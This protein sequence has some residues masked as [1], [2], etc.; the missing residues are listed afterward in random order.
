VN[1]KKGRNTVGRK[2]GIPKTPQRWAAAKKKEKNIC[3]TGKKKNPNPPAKKRNKPAKR[4]KG[5]E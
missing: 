5:Q 4:K 1:E 3:K 2:T